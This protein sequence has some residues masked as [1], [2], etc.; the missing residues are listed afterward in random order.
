M[1]MRGVGR[2]RL[3]FRE[4]RHVSGL[5][6]SRP[7]GLPSTAAWE[8]G[9]TGREVLGETGTSLDIAAFGPAR[10]RRGVNVDLLSARK[11]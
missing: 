8:V 11:V 1:R 3:R 9:E 10:L 4:M 6:A 7:C 2:R 5:A